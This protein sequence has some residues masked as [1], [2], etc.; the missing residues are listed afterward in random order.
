MTSR[1]SA[2]TSRN[3]AP[4]RRTAE[5]GPLAWAAMKP[6]TQGVTMNAAAAALTDERVLI[7][8]SPP[9]VAAHEVARRYGEGD[10]AAAAARGGPLLF[11]HRQL[12]A[13]LGA[14][15]R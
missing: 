12:A 4:G 9:A 3:R 11:P 7:D 2:R 13:V 10:T 6:T 8:H 1:S 14:S 5:R 15:G